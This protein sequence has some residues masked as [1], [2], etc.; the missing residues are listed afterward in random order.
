[1]ACSAK[2]FF[3]LFKSSAAQAVLKVDGHQMG[4]HT[5]SVAISNPPSRN[6]PVSDREASSSSY[7][8]SLGGGKKDTDLL[9]IGLS[10]IFRLNRAT[11]SIS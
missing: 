9:V 1:M 7:V 3:L 11:L 8:P 4:D 2:P 10:L 6:A 5:I